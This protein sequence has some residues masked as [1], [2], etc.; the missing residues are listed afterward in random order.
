MRRRCTVPSRTLPAART[1]ARSYPPTTRR[2]ADRPVTHGAD[3]QGRVVRAGGGATADP[4]VVRVLVPGAQP[5]R[6]GVGHGSSR[7]SMRPTRLR[8]RVPARRAT[9]SLLV[10]SAE[11]ARADSRTP[12]RRAPC[13]TFVSPRVCAGFPTWLL[14]D[15]GGP[16]TSGVPTEDACSGR[17]VASFHRVAR[18]VSIGQVGLLH[19]V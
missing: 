12:D 9:R 19:H 16:R 5:G 8:P 11:L 10:P 6:V 17:F 1:V 18:H 13:G 15:P 4:Q 2:R 14:L 3:S 7:G